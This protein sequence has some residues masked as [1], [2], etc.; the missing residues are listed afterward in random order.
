LIQRLRRKGLVEWKG[1][2]ARIPD[3]LALIDFAEFNPAYLSPIKEA[4]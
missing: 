2:T 3:L 1:Q 4:R